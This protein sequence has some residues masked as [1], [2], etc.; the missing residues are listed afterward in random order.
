MM[1]R[2]KRVLLQLQRIITAPME[3]ARNFRVQIFLRIVFRVAI[4]LLLVALLKVC[5]SDFFMI[6]HVELQPLFQ[7]L[8]EAGP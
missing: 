4:R 6:H 1:F 5:V 7:G 8:N 3:N 2:A